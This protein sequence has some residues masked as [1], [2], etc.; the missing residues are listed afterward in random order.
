MVLILTTISEAGDTFLSVSQRGYRPQTRKKSEM[1]IGPGRLGFKLGLGGSD[2]SGSDLKIGSKTMSGQAYDISLFYSFQ[3]MKEMVFQ[4]ECNYTSR[5]TTIE[6]PVDVYDP[7]NNYYLAQ[8]SIDRE[9]HMDYIEFPVVI[10]YLAPGKSMVKQQFE[11]FF[12]IGVAGAILVSKEMKTKNDVPDD[13]ANRGVFSY[14][15]NELGY[16]EV[17]ILVGFGGEL[18]LGNARLIPQMR[19]S[20][21]MVNFGSSPDRINTSSLQFQLGYSFYL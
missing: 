13:L 4:A 11:V 7:R 16:G 15:E 12:E 6:T 18:N 10:K 5:N 14:S 8:V 21:G 1:F 9:W 19:F 2:F 3:F 17:R 20:A